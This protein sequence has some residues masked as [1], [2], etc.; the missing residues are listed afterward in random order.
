MVSLVW[1]GGAVLQV[2]Q[3]PPQGQAGVRWMYGVGSIVTRTGGRVLAGKRWAASRSALRALAVDFV[4]TA[5]VMTIANSVS[6]M[7]AY[8]AGSRVSRRATS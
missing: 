8:L 2:A 4:A 6:L 7:V 3:P 5:N 1:I